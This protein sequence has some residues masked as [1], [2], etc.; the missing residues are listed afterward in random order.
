M[1]MLPVVFV[2]RDVEVIDSDGEVVR[3]RAMVPLARYGNVAARQFH[4]LEE[5]PLVVL[6]ARTRASHSHFFACVHEA[7]INLP[8]E[9]S[10]RWPTEEH[11]RKWVLIETGWFDEKDF[12]CPDERFAK[13]LATFIRTEDSYARISLHQVGK[14]WRVI[15]RRAKSQ[16]AAAMAKQAFEDS[17]RDVLDYLASMIGTTRG[18]IKKHAGRAA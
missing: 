1:K 16:S 10:V 13:R 6:E 2:W 17:K 3:Q 18:Q 11:M 4:D 7:F 12:D 8:E 15:V 5:Y 14:A 9:V